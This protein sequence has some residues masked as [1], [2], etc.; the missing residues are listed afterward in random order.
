[1]TYL[2]GISQLKGVIYGHQENK[3]ELL[4]GAKIKS[5]K[6]K[7]GVVSDKDGLFE[8]TLSKNLPDTLI[9]SAFGFNNDTL[10]VTNKDRFALIEINLF[11]DNLLPEVVATAKREGHGILKLKVLQVEN[12]G[13]GE[14]RKAACC[15][16]SESFLTNVSVDVS[17]TDAISGAKK[18]Q[19]MGLDGVY[20]AIQMENIPYIKG[21]ES[22]Y[23]LSTISGTWIESI[24]ITKG[25]G[26]VVNGYESMAGLVNLELKK[27]ENMDKLYFNAYGNIFGRAEVNLIS[28]AKIGKKWNT[29]LFLYG[30]NSSREIDQNKDGFRDIP[31]SK[32]ASIL[33]R[34]RYDGKKMEAQF[35][36]NS[37]CEERIGGQTSFSPARKD[38]LYGVHMVLRHVDL[39]AKT[40]FFIPKKPYA[41][42][43]IVYNLKYQET[44]ALF[45]V[46]QFSSVEK[47]GY[48]NAIYDG[49]IGNTN[50]GF[51]AGFSFVYSDI[52]QKVD[53]VGLSNR[54][55]LRLAR[56]EII[57]GVFSEYTYKGSRLT[58]V[59]GV[60]GD[61]HNLYGFQFSP[62]LHGKFSIN[63]RLDFRF[64]TGKAF[65]VS[66]VI[67][68][69]ISLLSSSRK[70]IISDSILPEISWNFG[71]SF[72]QEFN[73]RKRK[74]NLSVDY[75][76]T[77]FQ[78][79]LIV[80]RDLAVDKIYFRNLIGKSYSNSFQVELSLP[81]S[82]TLDVRLAYKY[83]NVKATFG[84]KMQQQMMIPKHRAFINLAFKT[85]N[86]RWEYDFTATVYGKSRL[87][88]VLLPDSSF[89]TK[90]ESEVYPILNAQI[91][92]VYKVW[93]FY[94]GGENIGNYIQKDAL[95]DPKNPYGS[96][97]DATRTWAPIQGINVYVGVRYKIKRAKDK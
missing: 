58:T 17:T 79:Q 83:L 5:I 38:S 22:S 35:G 34:W 29:A 82:N 40:G 51:K 89:T 74:S 54:D 12:I 62:R 90:N 50:H 77:L 10:I 42:V 85:R 84:N 19:M 80:D 25:T 47:R 14:L 30:A 48:I 69:N 49:I 28:S 94:I 18:I 13:E 4:I 64:T 1:M 52:S 65:R 36:I 26:N 23:G 92:H 75:Y 9:F 86:K 63:E 97:F 81:I 72:N 33:N 88:M 87:N 3:R 95:I 6:T 15:N 44:D 67:I 27:P 32:N 53:S 31:L 24:Q 70:W 71:G 73:F 61:Y 11:A 39:F 2:S 20:T 66:N 55:S 37:Y 96:F 8:I 41:S 60:R 43:G 76:H 56:I 7:K 59:W 46:R 68:D 57:P 78:N 21:L 45:G 93:D 16:L 91:T